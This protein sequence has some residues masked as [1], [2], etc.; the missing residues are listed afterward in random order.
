[1]RA[2]LRLLGSVLVL[3]LSTESFSLRDCENRPGVDFAYRD[4][5]L[6]RTDKLDSGINAWQ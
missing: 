5:V 1:M 2:F 6:V 3:Y 4:V